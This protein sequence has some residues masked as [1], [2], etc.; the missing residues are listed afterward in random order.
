MGAKPLLDNYGSRLRV[1]PRLRLGALWLVPACAVIAWF[2]AI[3]YF[4]PTGIERSVTAPDA[5]RV[6]FGLGPVEANPE[7]TFRW[8]GS[9]WSVVL[10]G[11]TRSAPV[12]ATLQASASRPADQP[13]AVLQ[14]AG[15]PSTNLRFAVERRWRSYHVFVQP[16]VDESERQL[17]TL[18]S[19]T[20][21]PSGPGDQRQLGVA[22]EYVRVDQL[23]AP[24]WWSAA[25]VPRTFFLA[26]MTLL[27]LVALRRV[28]LALPLV[29]AAAV[30]VVAGLSWLQ[31]R[32][33]TT[34][35]YWLPT[36][37]YLLG[38][39]AIALAL[40][41]V[42]AWVRRG[43]IVQA[44]GFIGVLLGG[45]LSVG[46]TLAL[47]L[48]L[49]LAPALFCAVAGAA[50]VVAALPRAAF[51][52]SPTAAVSTADRGTWA[53]LLVIFIIGLGLRLYRLNDLPVAVWRDEVYHGMN[54]L[55]IWNNPAYRPIY[56][57][58]VDLPA[59]LFYLMAPVIGTFGQ[60][61][62]T[63]RI[64][65]ALAGSLTPLAIWF[66]FRPMLGNRIAL[67]AAWCMAVWAWGLYMSRWAF[68]VILDPL[69]TLLALGC[70]WRG[71][72]AGQRRRSAAIWPALGGFCTGLATYTYHTGR[73]AVVSV[74][75]FALV[76]LWQRRRLI[77]LRW[78]L[79]VGVLTY[80]VVVAPLA[81]YAVVNQD[82]FSKRVNGVSLFNRH[83]AE[84]APPLSLLQSNLLRYVLMWNVQSD[85]NA[86]H[87]APNR[88][89]LDPVSG[90]L[91]LIGIGICLFLCR[92]A[93][94]RLLLIWLAAGLVSGVLSDE[95]PHAMR[96]IG[97]FAPAVALAA[98]G[99]DALWRAL[100]AR[101]RHWSGAL[102]TAFAAAIVLWNVQV[103]F[104]T[105]SDQRV[106][107]HQ[108][109]TAR[110]LITRA[111]RA[112][113]T[114]PAADGTRY[115]AYL[116]DELYKGRP[117]QVTTFLADGAPIGRFDGATLSPPVQHD[118]LLLLPGDTSADL[119]AAALRALGP[120]ARR[121]RTGPPIPG[122][123]DPIYVI[124]GVGEQAQQLADQLAL[125]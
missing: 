25:F 31:L 68:P 52:A 106:M 70:V 26:L 43:N 32:A 112:V 73:L 11:F 102:A 107:Y 100:P 40:P 58:D 123:A 77:D 113:A 21:A 51:P 104:A 124:F 5:P 54:A 49:P 115:Q 61:I 41:S 67:I 57:S 38:G 86:R 69:F 74:G 91:F 63:L 117:G 10:F 1:L 56:V 44:S 4:S 97:S 47:W 3:V 22:V 14:L 37:W 85:S 116:W 121:L 81:W 30:P 96:S 12:A 7:R 95:A 84:P 64:V 23:P 15:T 53:A 8:S 103:Y 90:A 24:N 75:L 105:T 2:A 17:L 34:F 20:F 13:E 87:F 9:R 6:L 45:L 50:L 99:L 89:M 55:E 36:T 33:T 72:E 39:A 79:L 110:T 101:T 114:T 29:V 19:T 71:L 42:G 94:H 98:I 62:W 83:G 78:A 18:D 46:G 76:R 66:A 65:P 59:L 93:L 82:D 92:T 60:D 122:A 118:A 35:A 80:A 111:A 88:P 120:G 27:S 109:E 16:Q 125:P 28:G 119:Q 48:R 108:F